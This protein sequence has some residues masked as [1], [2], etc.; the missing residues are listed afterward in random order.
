VYFYHW[1]LLRHQAAIGLQR[2]T[3]YEPVLL[4][5]TKCMQVNQIAVCAMVMPGKASHYHSIGQC[6]YE[7]QNYYLTKD[8]NFIKE[9]QEVNGT[10]EIAKL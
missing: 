4:L 10:A 6:L 9:G 3:N 2:Q 1:W 5:L 8:Q 7:L